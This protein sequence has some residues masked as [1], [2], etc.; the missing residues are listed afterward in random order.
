MWLMELISKPS[1]RPAIE[2]KCQN[3]VR[4]VAGKMRLMKW[5]RQFEALGLHHD[6]PLPLRMFED[7]K[8][9]HLDL[10]KTPAPRYCHILPKSTFSF[11]ECIGYNGG[12]AN[13]HQG[14]VVVCR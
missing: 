11:G 2:C 12:N 14:D 7:P 3:P 6:P 13:C 10:C 8:G 4:G 9:H 1:K 5:A